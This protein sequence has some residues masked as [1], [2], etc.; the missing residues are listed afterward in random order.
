MLSSACTDRALTGSPIARIPCQ[1]RSISAGAVNT[2]SNI[3]LCP[4]MWS[5]Y[6]SSKCGRPR[7]CGM[8][9]VFQQYMSTLPDPISS[10]YRVPCRYCN[11][12][13]ACSGGSS[14][15]ERM[16]KLSEH[17]RKGTWLS[18]YDMS[19]RGAILL[20]LWKTLGPVWEFELS[21]IMSW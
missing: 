4:S 6:P 14:R 20:S 21:R 11:S 10:R 16:S 12:R 2:K 17:G 7:S 13:S 3:L 18:A 5:L 9:L 8:F 15:L 19:L 1:I